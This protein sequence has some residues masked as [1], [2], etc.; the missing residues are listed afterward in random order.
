MQEKDGIEFLREYRAHPDRYM[1]LCSHQT[2]YFP[3]K[4]EDTWDPEYN[5]G[6]NAGLIE[7]N[8]PYFAECWAT[9]G[10]TI[11]TYFVVAEGWK[12]FRE[13]ELLEKLAKADL[14]HV[15]DPLHPQTTAVIFRDTDGKEYFSINVTVGVEE[16]T[17]VSGGLIYPCHVLNEFNEKKDRE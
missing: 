15:K 4:E 13:K 9:S 5:V 7:G 14:I 10:I 1:P 8:R 12:E 2:K 6:W 16:E 17:Y 11:M 3:P